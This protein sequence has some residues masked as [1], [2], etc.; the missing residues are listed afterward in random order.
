MSSQENQDTKHKNYE[1]PNLR[2][3]ITDSNNSFVSFDFNGKALEFIL[4]VCHIFSIIIR[5]MILFTTKHV[6]NS[7]VYIKKLLFVIFLGAL[8]DASHSFL[9]KLAHYFT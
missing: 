7:H 1:E 3:Y 2:A 8:V 4:A 9:A 6:L 5:C